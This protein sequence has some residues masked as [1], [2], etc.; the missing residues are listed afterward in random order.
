MYSNSCDPGIAK[1][2]KSD[3]FDLIFDS[4]RDKLEKSPI[5]GS[6]NFEFPIN[7]DALSQLTVQIAFSQSSSDPGIGENCKI[8]FQFTISNCLVTRILHVL[9]STFI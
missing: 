5:P 4:K 6:V 2:T 9:Q 8:K 1:N 7:L 3:N